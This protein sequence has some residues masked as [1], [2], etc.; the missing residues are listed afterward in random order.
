MQYRC[1]ERCKFLS[2]FTSNLDEF[3]MIRVGSLCDMSAVDK[4]RIDNKSGM[5][6]KEQLRPHLYGGRAVVMSAATALLRMWISG[7]APEGLCR[8]AISDLDPA[9]HKYIK[10]YFKNV[11]APVLS[12]QIVDAHHP[13]PPS[14]GQ[15]VAHR[16]R[17]SATKRAN[18][19]ACCLCPLRCPRWCSFPG[20]GARYVPIEDILL[21][22]TGNVFEMYD[23]LEKTVFCV[24]RNADI[25]PDDETFGA[26]EGDFRKKNGKAAA[27]APPHGCS[28]R[29]A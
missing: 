19:S 4:D 28:A 3:F 23:V 8:L 10:Q 15:G 29:R 22:Y 9:E 21:E 7:C 27:H 16:P 14:G 13:F 2:I 12:P 1:S 18:G 20:D 26:E 17:C 11:V 6:A 5:T 25:N 24:T